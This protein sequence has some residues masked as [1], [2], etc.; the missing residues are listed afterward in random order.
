MNLAIYKRWSDVALMAAITTI[1]FLPLTCRT[2]DHLTLDSRFFPG[3]EFGHTILIA[4]L[5]T[6]VIGATAKFAGS[7]INQFWTM[8]R[9]P[10]FWISCILS[11]IALCSLTLIPHVGG[12]YD[13]VEWMLGLLALSICIIVAFGFLWTQMADDQCNRSITVAPLERPEE[14][15]VDFS[16]LCDWAKIESPI[17][18]IDTDYLHRHR[19]ASRLVRR[20]IQAIRYD[21]L[22][23]IGLLGPY[24]SGKTSLFNLIDFE[25]TNQRT[26]AD[27]AIWMCRVSC[28][29][30]D[31]SSAALAHVL[32]GVINK[33][34]LHVDTLAVRSLPEGYTQALSAAG[35]WW[36]VLGFGIATSYNPDRQLR[37]L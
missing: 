22:L 32:E 1:L 20:F 5:S 23:S 37:R 4:L 18:E 12:R 10:P 19:V 33:L 14:D 2:T 35:S 13:A 6:L 8:H 31:D 28:W 29:G 36:Q 21:N 34:N 17:N 15:L 26:S 25:I 16:R 24:G 3:K 11:T 7:N 30:F 27:P 9:Y